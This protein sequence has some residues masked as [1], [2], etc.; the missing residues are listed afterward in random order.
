MSVLFRQTNAVWM[1]FTLAVCLLEDFTPLVF[2]PS[3]RRRSDEPPLLRPQG[4]WGTVS[5]PPPP[6]PPAAVAA[7]AAAAA[8]AGSDGNRAP[9][10]SRLPLSST[11]KK[12]KNNPRSRVSPGSADSS[13]VE[14]ARKKHLE[15]TTSGNGNDGGDGDDDDDD[16]TGAAR[17]GHDRCLSPLRSLLLLA[18]AALADAR[19]G[20]PL[21]RARAPLA[22]PIGLFAVFV[23]G[24]NGGAIVLGD[25][26]NHS[27]GGPPH[28]AQLAY[29]VAVGASLWG[30]VGGREAVFGR[31]ARSGFARWAR[32]RSVAGVAAI[33]AGVAVAM[34]R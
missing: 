20:A 22:A 15:E 10:S 24:F 18:K 34:W 4:P 17:L 32:E 16:G 27:P 11:A 2:P 9:P 31:D 8:A 6:P 14:A 33:V 23:W 26:E 1:A 3:A 28:L 5:P 21:L 12:R 25:K 29:L 7:E 13:A 19:R 30:V